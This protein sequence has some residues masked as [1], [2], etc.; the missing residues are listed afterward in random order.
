M[1]ELGPFQE[2]EPG[3]GIPLE[4]WERVLAAQSG[5]EVAPEPPSEV[6]ALVEEREAARARRDWAAADTLRKQIAALGWQV[7]D[8]PTGPS[9]EPLSE[10]PG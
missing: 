8:T 9:L 7:K 1:S 2:P 6:L 4:V 5:A 10:M 3:A